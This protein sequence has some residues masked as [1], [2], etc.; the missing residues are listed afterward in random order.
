MPRVKAI[1]ARLAVTDVNRSATFFANT[2][3]FQVETLWPQ[4]GRNIGLWLRHAVARCR[5]TSCSSFQDT[6]PDEHRMGSSRLLRMA[7]E[8]L[9]SGIRT[10]IG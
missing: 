6:E 5:R 10:E 8:S 4:Q 2:L 9:D 1:E 3:G 7:E